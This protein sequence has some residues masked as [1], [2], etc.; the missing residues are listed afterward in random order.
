MTEPFADTGYW[1]A[2][3]NERDYLHRKAIQISGTLIDHRIVTT[4][5]VLTELLNYAS[6]EGQYLRRVAAETVAALPRRR[7]V[8]VI[9]QTSDQFFQALE[10]YVNRLDQGW[11]LVDCASFI[12]METRR[13]NQAL[14]FDHHFEQAGF[15]A[16]LRNGE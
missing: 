12:V 8:E 10:R 5:M 1:I 16:L 3:L 14:A 2:L 15:T 4:E 13:I 7:N 9:P 6:R 11:S